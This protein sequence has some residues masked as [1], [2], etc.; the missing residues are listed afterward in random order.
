MSENEAYERYD[1]FLD[2]VYP[3]V[4]FG[5]LSYTPSEVLKA[6]DPIAYREG[7]LDFEMDREESE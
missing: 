7:F 6:V 2:E 3:M 5:A 4:E 1:E